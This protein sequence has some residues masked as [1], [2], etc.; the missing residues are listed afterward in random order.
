MANDVQIKLLG[1]KEIEQILNK[2]P[3]KLTRKFILASWR[4]SAKPII[5]AAKSNIQSYSKSIA[6]TIGNIT[7][8]SK[9]YPTIYV[10][11]RAKAGTFKDKAWLAP[12]IE[13]GSSG[14]KKK[15]S[16]VKRVS[17][18][19]RFAWVGKIKRGQKFRQ[20]QPARPFMRPAIL[21]NQES[22]KNNFFREMK[23][24]LQKQVDKYNK[25]KGI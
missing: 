6:K 20:D 14:T 16:N 1:E 12:I 2:L 11:P 19:P 10:G 18:N 9:R 15:D 7:G 13:F 17:D 22:V 3:A 25:F 21:N 8:R 5:N 24:V 4:K 23:V